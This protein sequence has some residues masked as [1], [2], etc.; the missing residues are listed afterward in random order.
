MGRPPKEGLRVLSDDERGYLYMLSRAQSAPAVQVTRATM[1]LHVADGT[2]FLDAARVVGRRDGDAVARLVKRF[3]REGI[4]ALQPRHGGGHEPTYG[5]A[6]RERIL[7]EVRRTPCIKTDGT[8]TWSL[9]TLQKSLRNAPDG[10]PQI[11]TF[12]IWKVLR[13]E[14]FQWRQDQSWCETGR[15]KRKRKAG[16]VNVT[17]PHAELKKPHSVGVYKS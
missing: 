5:P 8:A 15:V 2:T 11:S 1:I 17:D 4:A 14:G 6:E 7:R 3:N 13:E 9:T 10:L 16:V 12:T